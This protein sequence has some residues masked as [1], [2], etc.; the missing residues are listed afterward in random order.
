M[1]RHTNLRIGILEVGFEDEVSDVSHD[2]RN[3]KTYVMLADATNHQDP[4]QRRAANNAFLCNADYQSR[5]P[6][7]NLTPT[8]TPLY[9]C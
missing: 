5:G 2:K 3:D 6:R 4:P 7:E 9:Q 8:W 1:S